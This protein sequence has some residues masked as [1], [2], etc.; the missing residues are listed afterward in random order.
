VTHEREAALSQ[1]PE[2]DD[3]AVKVRVRDLGGGA[4]EFHA[5][6][7]SLNGR[8]VLPPEWDLTP[9]EY[10]TL[11]QQR[12]R[13][14]GEDAFFA[15]VSVVAP[16]AVT[17]LFVWLVANP[18]AAADTL[19][20]P[21]R[22]TLGNA[23]ESAPKPLPEEITTA[24]GFV[25]RFAP[26]FVVY[27]VAVAFKNGYRNLPDLF[28]WLA[29]IG[30]PRPTVLNSLDPAAALS[31]DTLPDE[32]AA[33]VYYLANDHGPRPVPHERAE[34]LLVAYECTLAFSEALVGKGKPTIA[35]L[36]REC[37][38]ALERLLAY[39]ETPSGGSRAFAE[40][41]RVNTI[42]A[43]KSALAIGRFS[44]VEEVAGHAAAA[45][46]PQPTVQSPAPA[47]RAVPAE[48][49]ESVRTQRWADAVA[50]HDHI[51]DAW[52]DII[53]D[54]LAALDHS[55]LLDVT[56]PRTAKFI[57]AFGRAQDLRA[58][59]GTTYPTK[60]EVVADYLSIVRQADEAWSDAVRHA[61]H[62][63]LAWLPEGEAKRVRQASALLATAADESQPMH[64]R[65]DSAAKAAELL[66]KVTSFY[67]PEPSA[68]AIETQARLA[69][70]AGPTATRATQSAA[71]A[72]LLPTPEVTPEVTPEPR[73]VPVTQKPERRYLPMDG[74]VY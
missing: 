21:L 38:E 58:L 63:H 16:L 18:Q 11:V 22:E 66:A 27:A 3:P 67:L 4:V 33:L 41:H 59:H 35:T 23:V 26:L 46:A 31:I 73:P 48:S 17:A 43:V 13:P 29:Q 19:T 54:P 10:R 50:C 9:L 7:H 28:G 72:I 71:D 52:A 8:K 47:A 5:S 62:V 15:V 2:F 24:F 25:E 12:D 45:P 49:A 56:Q 68:T 55:L 51:S 60:D 34:R 14:T 32:I 37:P 74:T 30:R 65:A 6:T 39:C 44:G 1:Q 42:K 64:L 61:R 20:G 69:L 57:E 36:V 53:T 40:R 70:P